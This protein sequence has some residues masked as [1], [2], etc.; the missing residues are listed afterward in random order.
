MSFLILFSNGWEELRK[1][2]ELLFSM[3][4]GYWA[5]ILQTSV[6]PFYPS[7]NSAAP[8]QVALKYCIP[9]CVSNFKTRLIESI[10][11]RPVFLW[12]TKWTHHWAAQVASRRLSSAPVNKW[13]LMSLLPSPRLTFTPFFPSPLRLT[14]F[15]SYASTSLPATPLA[16]ISIAASFWTTASVYSV[17]SSCVRRHQKPLKPVKTTS[18]VSAC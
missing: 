15:H 18:Q 11:P 4:S 12:L 9:F 10:S 1:C 14:F 7:C 13:L 3:P 2:S 6:W 5:E 17:C 16:L 8:L